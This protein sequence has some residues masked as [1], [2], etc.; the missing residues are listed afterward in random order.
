MDKALDE[1]ITQYVDAAARVF[2]RVA[3]H[4]GVPVSITNVEWASLDVPQHGSTADGIDY[5]KH[6]YGVAISDGKHK[7]DV[8]LGENGEIN[9]FD[10][11]RLFKFA[12]DNGIQTP[13]GSLAEIDSAIQEAVDS[14]ELT[15]SGYLLYYRK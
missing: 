2:P 13:F 11:W 10:A 14:N 9:G 7:I 12:Q 8:D 15:Y 6:G 1:L 4:L 3:E 5:F